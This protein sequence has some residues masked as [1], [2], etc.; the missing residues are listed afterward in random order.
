MCHFGLVTNGPNLKLTAVK[1]THSACMQNMKLM[2]TEY[3]LLFTLCNCKS[4]YIILKR[5]LMPFLIKQMETS[6]LLPI[7]SY[8]GFYID[9]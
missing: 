9:L 5:N 4:I 3:S 2:K 1:N 6:Y 7:K 8:H